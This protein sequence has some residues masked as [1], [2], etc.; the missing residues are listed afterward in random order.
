[1][2]RAANG[3]ATV[4]QRDGGVRIVIGAYLATLN[5]D[6]HWH[7]NQDTWQPWKGFAEDGWKRQRRRNRR[8]ALS[9][10][11]PSDSSHSGGILPRYSSFQ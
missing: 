11:R 5:G 6:Q 1:V 4:F 9:A 3:L 8:D 10:S 7:G 2:R